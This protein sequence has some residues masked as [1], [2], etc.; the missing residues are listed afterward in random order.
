[1]METSSD[2]MCEETTV[3]G[4]RCRRIAQPD[5]LC[6]YHSRSAL[7]AQTIDPLELIDWSTATETLTDLARPGFSENC[8]MHAA[9]D[10]AT[11]RPADAPDD[12]VT[13][14]PVPAADPVTPEPV[15]A[16]DPVTPEPVPAA[17]PVTP[18]PV[19]AAD[20]GDRPR[21]QR[22]LRAVP[23]PGKS[24]GEE[25]RD[26]EA[27][28]TPDIIGEDRIRAEY[29]EECP[30]ISDEEIETW[31]ELDRNGLANATVRTYVQHLA[32]F[33][34]YAAE[35]GFDPLR[36]HRAQV[37]GYIA[38]K[39]TTGKPDS[40]G[41]PDSDMPY[42]VGYF[43]KF[44]T[45]LRHA[46]EAK[47][48]PDHTAGLNIAHTIRG[49][50]RLNGSKLPR[51]AKAEL[52]PDQLVDIERTAREG[53]TYP[54]ALLRAAIA[55][56]CDPDI[57]L[58]VGELCALTFQ[59]VAFVDAAATITSPSS[60]GD[61]KIKQRRGDPACSVAA[62][63]SLR[64]A[65]RMRMRANAR[66]STP[67]EAQIQAHPVFANPDTGAAYSRPG[68]RKIVNKACAS[69]AGVPP[70]A[71]G[72]LPALSPQQ[73]CSAI[74]T[75]DDPRTTRNLAMMA[76]C[77]FSSARAGN[78]GD[79]NVE[80]LQA[81]GRDTD[82][83]V[84]YT[85]LVDRIEPDGTVT[86]GIISR[87]GA[88]TLTDI[89]DHD[90]NSLHASG[91]ILAIHNTFAYGTKTQ[92]FHKN[93]YIVQP[94]W[95]A[96][97]VRLVLKWIMV[98][99]QL[100]AAARGIRLEGSHPLFASLKQPGE[101][102]K[103]LSD[104]LGGIVKDAM[105]SIGIP[106][107]EYS[108]H[109]LRKFRASYVLNNGGSMT[110]VMLH[111]GRSSEAEGLVYCRI[112]PRNPLKADPTRGIYD[113]TALKEPPAMNT[114]AAATEPAADTSAQP[115]APAADTAASAVPVSEPAS[116][117]QLATSLQEA[118]ASLRDTVRVLRDSGLDDAAI[119]SIAG[120]DTT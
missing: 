41:N 51:Q 113:Q 88:I 50:T 44:R 48:L 45:A 112:D 84:L 19:P 5:G 35:H 117:P 98:Y 14:E 74:E 25:S 116:T 24:T 109:S 66:G 8:G 6:P 22:H 105:V 89:L 114:A 119:A 95:S 91:L 37:K 81:M 52:R 77:A 70:A 85:P 3:S 2:S 76:H 87:I 63:R 82:G 39:M 64:E 110:D 96:C 11:P 79:F 21:R 54:A 68:L 118:I 69:A 7:P 42:S 75:G 103:R 32:P 4:E 93:K 94:G 106:P 49:Y 107:D 10:E 104:V 28:E 30:G 43:K 56:G 111:D 36:C 61:I 20:P 80:H 86:K 120:L 18:E 90:G 16:A 1:M 55:V 38:H 12:S 46:T 26:G 27:I 92:P 17:D 62:L 47:G 57:G 73:R 108:A 102:I 53:N 83:S 99:D 9:V 78:A 15:P 31:I 29:R 13:P 33:Y 67:T 23:E 71:R 60:G 101:P 97:P 65:H 100:L 59:D 34:R 58:T 40:S 72:K 115:P